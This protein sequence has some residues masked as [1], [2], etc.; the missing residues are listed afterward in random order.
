VFYRI[1]SRSRIRHLLD[2][3]H[4][5]HPISTI[6]TQCLVEGTRVSFSASG[7]HFSASLRYASRYVRSDLLDPF[8]IWLFVGK[9]LFCE[10]FMSVS[11]FLETICVFGKIC[12]L[13]RPRRNLCTRQ[14]R[15]CMHSSAWILHFRSLPFRHACD[16]SAGIS[17][18]LIPILS[19]CSRR[20]L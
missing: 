11:V 6:L 3:T 18:L 12:S 13:L 7:S 15:H 20:A 9:L 5:S 10:D 14:R 2:K 4:P 17:F 16:I 1:L 19:V 8:Q